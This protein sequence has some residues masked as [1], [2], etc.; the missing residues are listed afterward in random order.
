MF[1]TTLIA[2]VPAAAP[3]EATPTILQPLNS[4]VAALV[5][6][7]DAAMESASEW[8]GSVAL[9]AISTD[10]NTE[11]ESFNFDSSAELRRDIDR[12]TVKAYL[13]YGTDSASGTSVLTQRKMGTSLQYDYFLDEAE[14][15]YVYGNSSLEYD[16]LADL[17]MRLTIG[18]GAGYQFYEEADSKLS[19]ELGLASVTEDFEGTPSDDYLSLRLA[20]NLFERINEDLTL[21]SSGEVLPSLEESDDI[22]AKLDTKLALSLSEAMFTSFQ[23]VMDYD[24]TPSDGIDRVDNRFVL[25]LG[26]S[27]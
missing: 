16:A 9:S 8:T 24:N 11:T 23:W 13:N 17:D 12:F 5:A 19:G 6:P 25:S 26:W 1:I 15:T 20:A 4:S 27:F 14:T 21:T 10:G 22:I 18:A 2:F 3:A 7:Q